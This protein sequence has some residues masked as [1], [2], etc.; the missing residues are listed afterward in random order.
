MGALPAALPR[1]AFPAHAADRGRAC[2]HR[3]AF[4]GHHHRGAPR[5]V[6]AREGGEPCALRP[7]ARPAPPRRRRA[8]RS[9]R[10]GA[11]G[12]HAAH[13]RLAAS[14][15]RLGRDEGQ[16]THGRALRTRV[17]DAPGSRG[18]RAE[19]RGPRRDAGRRY[20]QDRVPH[21][22]R[23][24]RRGH[25]RPAAG[26]AHA[27]RADRWKPRR[28]AARLG[29]LDARGEA[30]GMRRSVEAIP[31]RE[32]TDMAN[33]LFT[34]VRIIDAT[35]A[36]PYPGEV[37]VQRNRSARVGRGT[38]SGPTA[39]VTVIDGAGATLMPGMCEAH[40]HFGWTNS[41]TL[42]AIQKL[43][44]EEHTLWAAQVAKQYLDMGWTSCVGAA[45]PKPR[46]DCVIRDAINSGQIPGPRYLAASQE[47]T[48]RG[49]L[50]DDMLPHLPFPEMS[51]GCV[52]DG[53][54]GM[55]KAVRMFLKYGVDQVKL[56]LSGDNLVPGA[57]AR[58]SWMSD[59][60]V[61]VAAHEVRVRGK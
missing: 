13:R 4:D 9:R 16:A 15:E 39:G 31:S 48:V 40:T 42:D 41:K 8:P 38:R 44:H 10:P 37:L 25:G 19:L 5:R 36:Q 45:T 59:E 28:G 22:A 2:A 61:A 21:L 20:V 6:G 12:R 27:G 51:F 24:R 11:R 46:L 34:N 49:S 3:R 26:G 53:P 29:A 56:N 43:P 60:E 58:T 50:G 14:R 57:D 23:H 18:L 35:G 54:D 47:I 32:E 55:R 30:R 7:A 52:V 17:A 33:V 1:K